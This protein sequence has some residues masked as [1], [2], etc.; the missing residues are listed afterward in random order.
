MALRVMCGQL[1]A[2]YSNS[3][4]FDLTLVTILKQ[5]CKGPVNTVINESHEDESS[6]NSRKIVYINSDDGRSP[7]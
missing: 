6:S 5:S 3:P 7:T 2:Y 4:E 1:L